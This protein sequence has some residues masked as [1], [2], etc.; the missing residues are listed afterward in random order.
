[1]KT[2]NFT[3]GLVQTS[4]GV[5]L[6]LREPVSHVRLNGLRFTSEE[7]PSLVIG[8]RKHSVEDVF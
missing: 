4:A 7:G 6:C 8:G 1:M 3:I 2:D 5:A